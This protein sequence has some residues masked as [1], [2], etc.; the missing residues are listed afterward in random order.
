MRGSGLTIS[1]WLDIAF[2][3]KRWEF[4]ALPL[5]R[6][7]AD[8]QLAS[9]RDVKSGD[10]LVLTCKETGDQLKATVGR[11]VQSW[12]VATQNAEKATEDGVAGA[13]EEEEEE[14][15]ITVRATIFN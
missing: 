10:V 4:R 12:N 5:P 14:E 3:V 6:Q 7:N 2:G 15:G 11:R 9:I 13:E 1:L 8:K